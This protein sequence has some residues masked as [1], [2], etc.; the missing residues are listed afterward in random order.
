MA[1]WVSL[2][3]SLHRQDFLFKIFMVVVIESE[4]ICLYLCFLIY[5]CRKGLLI[6]CYENENAESKT[7]YNATYFPWPVFIR[8]IIL[9]L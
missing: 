3:R 6:A 5:Q 2:L 7:S 4:I 1:P 9:V 8:F